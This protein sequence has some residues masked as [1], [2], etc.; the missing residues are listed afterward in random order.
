MKSAK[1]EEDIKEIIFR[2]LA[3]DDYRVFIFGSR[4][5]GKSDRYSDY[6]IGIQGKR[7]LPSE[8]KILIEE[9][10]EE[11]ELPYKVDIVDFS[12]VSN[13]FKKIVLS[14]IRELIP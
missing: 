1:A 7:T 9:A 2:F 5:A 14:R 13:E 10:L 4:A 11:S 6:D 8:T 12:L 3:P